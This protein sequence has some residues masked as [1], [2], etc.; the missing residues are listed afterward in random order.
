MGDGDIKEGE[1]VGPEPSPAPRKK[2]FFHP[3]SGLVILGLDWLAFG[4]DFFSGFAALL[5]V[6]VATFA[7][8]F[9]LV[10]AIQ[11]RLHGDSPAAAAGK[12]FLG[13]V[14]AGVPF[15]VTGTIVGAAILAL[16]GLADLARRR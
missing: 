2:S 14:A 5:V 10:S 13:A 8:T 11:R 16:S 4:M 1:I 6:S 9:A 15:P 7:A 12:A 3:L